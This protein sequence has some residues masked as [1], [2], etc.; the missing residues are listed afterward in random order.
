[1]KSLFTALLL[2]LF[3]LFGCARPAPVAPLL[4]QN[5]TISEDT[6]WTGQIL[7]DGSV[8]VLRGATL[9][10]APGT[11][12][13]FTYLDLD[14]DGLG[15]G[16]LIVKGGLIAVG[17][18][19]QPIRFR[20]AKENPQPGDWQEIAVDFSSGVH[21]RYC[22]IRDSAY[23]LHAHFTHGIV[24]DSH[25]HNNID[26]CRIGQATFT[27]RHNLIEQQTGKGINFR[28]SRVTL[29]DNLIRNNVAGVFLFENDQPFSI[30]RNNFTNNVHQLRLGDFYVNDVDLAGNWWGTS[31]LQALAPLIY[32]QR[33]DPEVGRVRLQPAG[34]AIVGAGPRLPFTFKELWSYQTGGFVDAPPLV[35]AG[36]ALVPSWD[37]RLHALDAS[38]RAVWTT[39][40]GDVADAALVSDGERLYLQ[41]WQRQVIAIELA[42]GKELW[43][44]QYPESPADD[45]RQGGLLLTDGQL[46]VP[47]WN[48]QLYAFEPAT[49]Q[50]LWS[51]ATGAA[52]RAAPLVNAGQLY[53]PDSFGI[54]HCLTLQGGLLWKLDLAAP[55][56]ST[57][58]AVADGLVQITKT[59]DVVAVDQ[60]GEVL[61]RTELAEPCFYGASVSDGASVYLGT[62][63]AAIYSIDA[64]TGELNWRRPTS[65]AV[66][67]TPLLF[68]GR[69]LVGDN[70]GH[71]FALSTAGGELLADLD[72][73]QPLQST[74]TIFGGLLLVGSR[75]RSVHAFQFEF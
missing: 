59:G 4:L 39:A 12:I 40:L 66:Y 44:F 54:L 20:S 31:D 2:L 32:D 53:L 61:W 9:T 19:E 49:G 3:C 48:G 11:E 47:A 1:M 8:E 27:F 73:S 64:A 28:N 55:L 6:L 74:P 14:R 67:A 52:L 57:P 17:T 33:V 68:A 42:S 36:L 43:R 26:G 24:E 56:L 46:L 25:I 35:V 7:I 58:V 69:L 16:T 38:G 13:A 60:Q 62:A 18:P 65:G 10:I 23:T 41:T 21:F 34:A 63:G 29:H 37:G 51:Y 75:D 5:T 72:M 50:L 45:H 15:D 71:L 30:Y 70:A 22:D